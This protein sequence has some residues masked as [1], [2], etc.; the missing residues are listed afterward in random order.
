MQCVRPWHIDAEQSLF[1]LS[2]VTFSVTPAHWQP[3]SC[4]Q[5]NTNTPLQLSERKG[6]IQDVSKYAFILFITFLTSHLKQ[7]D[8]MTVCFALLVVTLF[9]SASS[10]IGLPRCYLQMPVV[11]SAAHPFI[12]ILNCIFFF[13]AENLPICSH[14]FSSRHLN[15]ELVSILCLS[16]DR[17]A[18]GGICAVNGGNSWPELY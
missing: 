7:T 3:T 18:G 15:R 12:L 5:S 4:C 17:I 11:S 8:I 16:S 6:S 10:C 14:F 1:T 2:L 13:N 9:F